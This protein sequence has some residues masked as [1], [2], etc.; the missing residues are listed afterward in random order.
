MFGD[1]MNMGAELGLSLNAPM[2]LKIMPA[3]IVA[4]NFEAMADFDTLE[5]A[6]VYAAT[7]PGSDVFPGDFWALLTK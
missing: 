5:A 7:I 2:K 1:A 4:L 6:N 3:W